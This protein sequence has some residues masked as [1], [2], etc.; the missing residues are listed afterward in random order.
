[1]KYKKGHFY[2][3]N[4]NKPMRGISSYKSKDLQDI[5]NKLNIALATKPVMYQAICEKID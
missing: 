3:E 2:I 4:V 1:M 5:C